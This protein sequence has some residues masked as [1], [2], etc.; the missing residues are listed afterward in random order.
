MIKVLISL[1]FWVFFEDGLLGSGGPGLL[2]FGEPSTSYGRY[3]CVGVSRGVGDKGGR[4]DE[5]SDDE[6]CGEAGRYKNNGKRPTR[7]ATPCPPCVPS[8]GGIAAGVPDPSPPRL[9]LDTAQPVGPFSPISLGV[10]APASDQAPALPALQA[11]PKYS[12]SVPYAAAERG[13]SPFS[14]GTPQAD[15]EWGA[16]LNPSRFADDEHSSDE[17]APLSGIPV[18]APSTAL[19]AAL[20]AVKSAIESLSI[21]PSQFTDAAMAPPAP[22]LGKPGPSFWQ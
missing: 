11:P 4:A 9:V 3:L 20:A 1:G 6:D 16:L 14:R 2:P 21:D 8:S 22:G 7:T 15:G 12:P 17:D 13:D 19:E 18:A 5:D 10:G